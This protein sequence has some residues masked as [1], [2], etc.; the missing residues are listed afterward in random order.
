MAK[1]GIMRDSFEVRTGYM[2]SASFPFRMQRSFMALIEV[3]DPCDCER[4]DGEKR[5]DENAAW[6][7][8]RIPLN[9]FA[10]STDFP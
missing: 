2:P 4:M 5:F 7:H 6:V 1:L 8:R 3:L 9:P 10:I